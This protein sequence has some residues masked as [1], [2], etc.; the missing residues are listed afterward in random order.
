MPYLRLVNKNND[1]LTI[2][3]S[4]LWGWAFFQGREFGRCLG[5]RHFPTIQEWKDL[6]LP[7]GKELHKVGWLSYLVVDCGE[8][9]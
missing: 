5:H 2:K 3:W 6:L 8:E 7:Y 4:P 9:E 1:I